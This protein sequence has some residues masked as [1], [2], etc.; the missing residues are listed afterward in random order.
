M[1]V[2]TSPDR[3]H[4]YWRVD[5][6]PLEQ[7]RSVQKAIADRFGGDPQ[8]H[9]LARVMRVPGFQ[10]RK[11]EPFYRTRIVE[12]S[13]G[14]LYTPAEIVAEF[15]TAS[16]AG[17]GAGAK[18]R[19]IAGVKIKE[20]DRNSTLTSVA[21]SMRRQGKTEDEIYAALAKINPIQCNP[22][23]PDSEVRAIAQSIER[24]APGPASSQG[25]PKIVVVSGEIPSIVDQA[26]RALLSNPDVELYQYSHRPVTIV[27]SRS[28]KTMNGVTRGTGAV[29]LHPVSSP[30]LV[31][32]FTK[33]AVW[34]RWDRRSDREAVID[35]PGRVATTYL[36]RVGQWRLPEIRGV[37]QAPTLREDGSLL[38]QSGYDPQTELFF[39]P[40][41][42]D[43]PVIPN[44]PDKDAAL[45]SLEQLKSILVGFPFVSDADRSVALATILTALVRKSIRSAPM[46]GIS[47]PTMGSGKTLLAD[48]VSMIATGHEAA[49]MSQARDGDE[50]KKRLLSIL[51][52][53]DP[54]IVIDN[55]ERPISGD[56]LCAILT[57]S[58]YRDRLLGESR[59]VT[60]PTDAVFIATG[61]NLAFHGDMTTRALLCKID[62]RCERPEE[63][64][65]KRNLRQYVPAHRGELVRAALTILRAYHVAGRP[66]QGIK[67]YG[68][69]EEWSDLVRAALV[70]LGEPDPVTTREHIEDVDPERRTLGAVLEAWR[71]LIGVRAVTAAKVIKQIED[72]TGTDQDAE[73][74]GAA[75]EEVAQD[76]SGKLN[77]RKLA[78]WLTK[79]EGRIVNGQK[80]QRAG[81]NGHGVL[82]W[83]IVVETD[84]N[85]PGHPGH[86]G[87]IHPLN[88]NWQKAPEQE[89]ATFCNRAGND[90]DDPDDPDSAG[91]LV[92]KS[93]QPDE[94]TPEQDV[95]DDEELQRKVTALLAARARQNGGV[96]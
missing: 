48:V 4:A 10:H 42:F 51:L 90:P 67:P 41:G 11:S 87:H 59:L 66:A 71:D 93:C 50:D 91:G 72:T 65:F 5:G 17:Q 3:Y 25:K 96:S 19:E 77:T 78:A 35:C 47:A 73:R 1:V 27:R 7:F 57:Q 46:F 52:A 54:V 62:P 75:L 21:G 63:R 84:P 2:E 85:D 6:L 23:L 32:A 20:G 82:R 30:W 69:F 39:E 44:D 37:I 18:A 12:A 16:D 24:Y 29:T 83:H 22:P 70:W 89:R 79:V 94:G 58:S 40:G 45:K 80:F 95:D 28:R 76:H 8:V 81:D 49:V 9:D 60:V 26:E 34:T 61:N 15:G 64:S 36:A 86:P 88:K 68:R 53:G 43:T 92:K 33:S 55:V 14:H 13:D 74:L 31:E 56:A 38:V